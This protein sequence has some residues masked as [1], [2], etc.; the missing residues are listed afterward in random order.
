[1]ANLNKFEAEI[2]LTRE[3]I[4]IAIEKYIREKYATVL[5]FAY[6]TTISVRLEHHSTKL[7]RRV[8]TQPVLKE[9]VVMITKDTDND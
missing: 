7:P 4:D 2:S 9:A 1:M 5:S 6:P 8:I 3:E